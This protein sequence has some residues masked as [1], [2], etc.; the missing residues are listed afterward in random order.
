MINQETNDKSPKSPA[1]E[2]HPV[3][4]LCSAPLLANGRQNG[5][6]FRLTGSVPTANAR[7]MVNGQPT[8]EHSSGQRRA[9]QNGGRKKKKRVS[10]LLVTLIV[11][12]VLV[13]AVFAGVGIYAMRYSGYDKILPNVYVAGIDIGGMTK[14]EATEAIET[15]LSETTQQSVN[16]NLPD[17]VL[18][19]TPQQDTILI[20]VDRAVEEAY[21]YGRTSTS[22]FAIARA[23][24]AAQRTRNDIDITSA[25]QVDTE[26]IHNLIDETAA[27]VN[28]ALVESDVPDRYGKPYNYCHHWYTRPFD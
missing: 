16:V 21:A 13:I 18:T 9:P 2:L 26:Y 20:N 22:P 1:N 17:R 8:D 15:A 4:N 14:E 12:L 24:K 7:Q 27:E 23:I 28:T 25:V 10:P 11:A 3:K 6:T 5:Q 19:F